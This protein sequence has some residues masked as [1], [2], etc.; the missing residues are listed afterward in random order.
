MSMK[1][2]TAPTIFP[3]LILGW[4]KYSAAK[5]VPSARQNTSFSERALMVAQGEDVE[6]REA[7]RILKEK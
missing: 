5:D 6:L 7:I 3:S 4:E 1:V 2:I